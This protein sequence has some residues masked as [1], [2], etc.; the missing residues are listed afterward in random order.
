MSSSWKHLEMRL[1]ARLPGSV[2]QTYRMLRSMKGGPISPLLPRHLV[3]DC[4]LCAD[5]LHLIERLPRG[6]IVAE[7][8]TYKGD[9]AR[10]IL[11]R[12]APRELHLIDIDYGQFDATDLEVACVRRH[13]GLTHEVIATFADASFDWIYIDADHSYA[14]VIRDARAAAAKIKPGGYAVFNS[15]GYCRQWLL[16][17][18]R[19]QFCFTAS[20]RHC[21]R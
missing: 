21:H 13:A 18:E 19:L 11:A 1:R 16:R 8:G 10:E 7:L 12:T 9:F 15:F 17:F 5:R 6:G 20:H 14:G 4:R 3:E 2:R